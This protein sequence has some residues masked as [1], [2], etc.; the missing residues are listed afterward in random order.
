MPKLGLT[1]TTARSSP[2]QRRTLGGGGGG[3]SPVPESGLSLWLK[4]DA[5]VTT[6]PAQIV[7]QIVLSGGWGSDDVNGDFVSADGTYTRSG[8]YGVGETFYDD[9]T[10]NYIYYNDPEW[11]LHLVGEF[12][13]G[14]DQFNN[15]G[16]TTYTQSSN[17]AWD[18][19][20]G[21]TLG[22]ATSTTTSIGTGVATWVDQSPNGYVFVPDYISRD[23][24]LSSSVAALNNLPAISFETLKDNG[25]VGL[26]NNNAF[27]TKS[28]FIVYN[29]TSID[30]FDYSIPYE[31]T[32][33][34]VYTHQP[35]GV[36]AFGSYF[37]DFYDSVTP[38]TLG[39]PYLRSVIT[40]DGTSFEFFVDGAA[41]GGD[42][43]GSSV[44]R[45][46]IVIGNGG[47]RYAKSTPAA[48]PINQAF[49]G[50]I[51]EIVAYDRVLTTPERQQVEAYLMA[52]YD[53]Y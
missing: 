51:A 44:V 50:N 49:Q 45:D 15:Y 7:T 16:G 42:T 26:Y 19:Q 11:Y 9:N 29:L 3:A 32:L 18:S 28:F 38:S 40:E 30:D 17:T 37:N 41:D 27:A 24:T 8:A 20:Y 14:N 1:H 2:R 33:I 13:D 23:I 36:R 52:K 53:L 48:T 35:N 47:S 25:F 34:N 46:S 12:D 5:G 4:A 22:T 39:S 10:G 31:N 43:G 6:A 21:G